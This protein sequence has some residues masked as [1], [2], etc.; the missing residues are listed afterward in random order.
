MNIMHCT[1]NIFF[2]C[3]VASFL[4]SCASERHLLMQTD[5]YV[6]NVDN[7]SSK[8]LKYSG[9]FK[10]VKAIILENDKVLIG[11]ID[12][13]QPYQDNLFV[14]D[15]DI[16]KG[17]YVFNKE[18]KFIRK[19][20]NRGSAPGEYASCDDFTINTFSD[21]ALI[22][23]SYHH[24][25]YTY[26]ILS[27]QFKGSIDMDKG[28]YFTRMV[29][30]GGYLYT[31]NIFFTP[32]IDKEPFYLLNQMD[33]KTGK[34]I[35][36][37]LN[38]EQYNKGWLDKLLQKSVFYN[39]GKDKS[40][41]AYGLMDSI[42]CIEKGTIY[43][44]VAIQSAGIVQES[45]ISIE[46]AQLAD[47]NARTRNIPTLLNKL[48]RNEKILEVSDIFEHNDMLYFNFMRKMGYTAQYNKRT[49]EL[50][51]F[52][53]T[54]N[55]LLFKQIP[56]QFQVPLFLDADEKGVFYTVQTE[57]LTE[58]KSFATDGYLSGDVIGKRELRLLDENSNPVILYYEY[59]D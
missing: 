3:L 45:D 48:M 41:F 51:V 6:M 33:L 43:P 40:L 44:Y 23:D 2:I 56:N 7:V 19:I 52:S 57:Y 22:Y 39:V 32:G 12:R 4:F 10:S 42:F 35:N 34:P 29:F 58:L 18:G 28:V 16:A 9:I 25:I 21:E 26:D 24:K 11:K 53:R 47:P 30:N 13:M 27:G 59:R 54:K 20:G 5:A 37:W 17:L 31:T 49:D 38:A 14:L 46:K 8:E 1:K 15:T 55:D 50:S 36:Q